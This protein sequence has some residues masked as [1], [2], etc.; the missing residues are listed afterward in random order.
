MKKLYVILLALAMVNIASE[1]KSQNPEIILEPFA[2][3][4]NM[5]TD[6]GNAGDSRL[7]VAEQPGVIRII[8]DNGNV[9]STPFLDIRILVDTSHN[10]RGLLGI[11][12]HPD[13]KNN[14]YFYVNYTALPNGETHI[15]RFSVSGA[16]SN[17]ADPSSEQ[18]ILTQS[19]PF[20]NHN[21]G[22]LHFGPDSYL[23]FGLGDGGSG[24]DPLENAQDGSTLLG[25]MIRIDVNG[26]AP[27]E[28]PS[29]NPFV[30]DTNILDEIWAMGV[31]NP[32]RFSFD[33]NTGDIWIADVGQSDWEEINYEPANG[34]GGMNWG[35]NCYEGSDPFDLQGCDTIEN[36]DFPVFEYP[37]NNN[38]G[39]AILGGYVYRGSDYADL[40]GH[41]LFTDLCSG[42]LWTLYSDG[43][44][45]W[46]TTD[47][48]SKTNNSFT[49]FGQDHQG[50]LYIA[51]REGDIFK[52]TTTDTISGVAE[53]NTDYGFHL[54]AARPN[55]FS[56]QLSLQYHL[57]R[58]MQVK[59][60]VV[61][62]LGRVVKTLKDDFAS[63]GKHHINWNVEKKAALNPGIYLL[64]FKAEDNITIQKISFTK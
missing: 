31:R 43:S 23:Y 8:S 55:P 15:S 21:A 63:Q 34:P 42:R 62:M 26:T 22:A 18:I 12:F 17:I 46:D 14:G 60:E 5:V 38:Y 33:R 64:V 19:Q 6:I 9:L 58:P 57:D 59:I 2:S 28:I 49:T 61:D 32:F 10:E 39:C 36:Y 48:G 25:K 7:F 4:L 44:G 1:S 11:T 29:T 52:I 3:G 27:Y 45:G 53:N 51:E 41:Y 20:G 16:D 47:Q 13:Y 50:E 40:R 35:W 56:S 30:N 24:G 37:N 54:W